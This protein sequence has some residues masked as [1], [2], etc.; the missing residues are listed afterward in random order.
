[1]KVKVKVKG[2]LGQRIEDFTPLDV[3]LLVTYA[4]EV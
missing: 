4:D 2:A 1:V 3:S